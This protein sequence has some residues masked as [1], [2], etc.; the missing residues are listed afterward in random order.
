MTDETVHYPYRLRLEFLSPS[1]AA[2]YR[3][4]TGL[5]RENFFINAKVSL[6]DIFFV[7]RPN[8]NV[9]FSNKLLRKNVDFL[10]LNCDTLEP[11]LAI[12]LDFPKQVAHGTVDSFI[13]AVCN[14][15]GL[16]LLHITVQH[17]YDL[18]EL[19]LQIKN[20]AAKNSGNNLPAHSDFS[21]VC[22][23]C[24]ITMV[25]RFDKDGP[26]RGQKYY[27]CLN[28]PECQEIVAV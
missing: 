9:Q 18:Y 12:E 2:F 26:H 23:R 1:E 21:P 17:P 15:A 6:S 19:T 22:P 3:V 16:P 20:M 13:D 5:V 24:G 11:S 10:L 27:G 7:A 8:E 25:L 14:A 28:F 4:L